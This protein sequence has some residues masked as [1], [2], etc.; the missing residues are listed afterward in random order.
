M[1]S[2]D[3]FSTG[4]QDAQILVWKTNFDT[5]IGSVKDRDFTQVKEKVV[6]EVS[7]LRLGIGEVESQLKT[8]VKNLT[9]VLSEI[10]GTENKEN[11][12]EKN[13]VV[14]HLEAVNKK[15]DTLT[16]TVL[17]MEKRLTL[18]EDQIRIL[19]K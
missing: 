15:L 10:G 13:E 12:H 6:Q 17:L 3:V 2:S 7:S 19:S 5:E 18:V 9:K 16:R 8:P 4:G 1:G 11:A 14:K